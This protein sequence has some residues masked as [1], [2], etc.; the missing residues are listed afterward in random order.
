M[1]NIQVDDLNTEDVKIEEE[2]LKET[3]V[4]EIKKQVM[5][6]YGVTEEANSEL[7][8]RL[9][10]DK[11]EERKTLGTAI[12]QKRSWRDK[13]NSVKPEDKKEDKKEDKTILSQ[14]E[15]D[16]LVD[17][18]LNEKLDAKEIDSTDL[19]DE[20]KLEVKSYA[21]V[22]KVSIKEA[23]KSEYILFRI[24]KVKEKTE[25]DDASISNKHDKTTT[26]KNFKDMKAED[27][28]VTTEQGRKDW[29]EYK[30]HLGSMK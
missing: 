22:N 17:K 8:D 19:S 12:K 1:E 23:L 16:A 26:S 4:E 27:F 5:E 20:L 2:V 18:K 29:A 21:A 13:F 9:V 10:K 24:G 15:I 3:P 7:I 6:K 30:K 11:L 25:L 28:D 14:T